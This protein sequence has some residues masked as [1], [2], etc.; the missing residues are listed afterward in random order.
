MQSDP[1]EE[2]QR[3]TP[4][5]GEMGDIELRELAAGIGDL[6]ETAQQVLRDELKKRGIPERPPVAPMRDRVFVQGRAPDRRMVS[7]FV[8]ASPELETSGANEEVD[9]DEDVDE[10]YEYTWK[11]LLCECEDMQQATQ[12]C[13]VLSHEGIE[14]WIEGPGSN[15]RFDL[16]C[17]R[18]IVAADQLEQ[19][20]A[21][22]SQP[23]SRNVVDALASEAEQE[24]DDE[25]FALPVCPKCGAADPTLE[26]VDPA[27]SWHCESCDNNWTDPSAGPSAGPDIR[28][29]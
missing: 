20:R 10:L 17:P 14:S 19:A 1:A 3:L 16:P 15:N 2:W 5:Y 27:N 9:A 21:I 13:S 25:G 8:P 28:L 18:V 22:V 23:V 4:L 29:V 26:N 6:T 11:T 7:H 12:I 24:K